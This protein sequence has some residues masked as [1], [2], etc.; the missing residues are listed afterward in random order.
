MTAHRRHLVEKLLEKNNGILPLEPAWVARDF[1]P[2]GYRLGLKE[3]EYEVG[4]RGWISERWL[5]STTKADNLVGPPDEGLS[6]LKTEGKDR[7]TL[8]EAV[9]VAGDLILGKEYAQSHKGLGRLAKIFDFGDRIPYHLHQMA[10]DAAR[11]GRNPKEEAYYFPEGPDLGPHPETFFGVHPYIRDQ[12]K[13]D[14]LLPY[15][16]GWN[17]DLILK[18]SRAYLNVAGEGFHLPAG[19]LHAPG[20]ALTIEL[21]EDSDV[22]ALLQALVA[23]KIISKKLLF[24]DVRQEDQEKWGERIILDQINW[25]ISGDPF[26]YENRHLPPLLVEGSRQAGGE[27]HWIYYNTT[28]FSGKKLAVKPAQ[29]FTSL[30]SGVYSVLVWQ[31]QGRYDGQE[32]KAG[33][34]GSDELLVCHEKATRPLVIENTGSQELVLIKFFGPDINLNAPTIAKYEP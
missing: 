8:K 18:H 28:K 19:V 9:E 15:L 2:P 27:E 13:Y 21:Q 23:G 7:L 5:A 1:L 6:Y 24:K 29:K 10:K 31:G 30:D 14:I 22:F 33:E 32:V 25:E 12:K 17:S 3:S 26:F 11:V 34:F 4:E 20:T 16:V